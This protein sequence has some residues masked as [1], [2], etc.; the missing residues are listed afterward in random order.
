VNG[1]AGR[2]FFL[3]GD[4]LY[5]AERPSRQKALPV[6]PTATPEKS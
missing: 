3:D 4:S 5:A 6:W 1:V 2:I